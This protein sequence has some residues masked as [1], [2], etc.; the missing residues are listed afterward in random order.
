MFQVTRDSISNWTTRHA[1]QVRLLAD[2]GDSRGLSRWLL[3]L[4]DYALPRVAN[5]ALDRLLM[6][7]LPSITNGTTSRSNGETT[8]YY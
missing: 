3:A 8:F 2:C 7:R 5:L 1:F 4:G 6:V